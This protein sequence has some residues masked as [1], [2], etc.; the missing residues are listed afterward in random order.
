[1]WG[2]E[3]NS[4]SSFEKRTRFWISS[5]SKTVENVTRH[6][7]STKRLGQED[8]EERYNNET[9]SRQSDVYKMEYQGS[10]NSKE[11]LDDYIPDPFQQDNA[12]CYKIVAD[13]ISHQYFAFGKAIKAFG[14]TMVSDAL[15][16]EIVGRGESIYFQNSTGP[17]ANKNNN[18]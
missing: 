9:D 6:H 13:V 14:K 4:D 12:K 8:L 17:L 7:D 18:R 15:A 16:I 5:T 1:M 10:L 11:D 3:P 2:V